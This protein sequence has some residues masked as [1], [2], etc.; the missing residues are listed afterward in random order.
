MSVCRR[1]QKNRYFLL[2]LHMC[3]CSHV[4]DC[5]RRTTSAWAFLGISRMHTAEACA[6]Y[7]SAKGAHV[8]VWGHEH[9][10]REGDECI[11]GETFVSDLCQGAA[12]EVAYVHQWGETQ[13]GYSCVCVW[14]N[15][16]AL[17]MDVYTQGMLTSRERIYCFEGGKIHANMFPP[18]IYTQY[19]QCFLTFSASF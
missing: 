19:T 6:S 3:K 11:S 15:R 9:V 7:M 8:Q 12:G 2:S 13:Y 5:G 18:E 4:S 14:S 10:C 1:I 17:A 16:N